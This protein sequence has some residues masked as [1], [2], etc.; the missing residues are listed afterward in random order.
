L[1][2]ADFGSCGGEVTFHS[3]TSFRKVKALV[4]GNVEQAGSKLFRLT[5]RLPG[6]SFGTGQIT[7][8]DEQKDFT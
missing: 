4:P 8:L 7:A 1:N 2:A 5:G 3:M 6:C